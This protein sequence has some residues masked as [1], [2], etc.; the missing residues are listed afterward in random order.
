V[1]L[2]TYQPNHPVLRAICSGSRDAFMANDME[3]RRAAKMPPFG[4][5]IALIIEAAREDVLRKFC[6]DLAAA[7]PK[8][9]GGKIMGPIEAG[10][11]QI[12]GWYRM[13]FLVAGDE[14]ANLQPIV[15]QWLDKAKQP[16]NVRVKI[17]VN[18]QNFM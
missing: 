11:F 16:A 8:L 3:S 6:A 13:R 7:A 5:L 17:D 12:R 10:V 14:R 18:P 15:R 9:S 4:Q 1:L 2:Q